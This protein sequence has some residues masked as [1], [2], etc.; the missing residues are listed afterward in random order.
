[1][2]ISDEATGDAFTKTGGGASDKNNHLTVP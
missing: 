1:M 2:T